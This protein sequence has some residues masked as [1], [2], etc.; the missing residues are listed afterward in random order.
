MKKTCNFSIIFDYILVILLIVLSL[1][2]GGFYKSDILI[3]SIG[4][5]IIA[6]LY[7]LFYLFKLLKEKKYKT[8]IISILLL[9][10]SFCYLLPIMFNNYADLNSSIF[11]AIRY[12]NLYFIYSIVKKTN[13]KKVYIYTI[14]GITLL[15]CI[16]S[17]DG[18]GNRYLENI[19]TNFGSGYLDRDFTRMSGTLQYA[20][21]L[22]I[23]CLISLVFVFEFIQNETKLFNYILLYMTL[24]TITSA[25][26][27]TG[28]RAVFLLWI[29]SIILSF[30]I[31]NKEI[32]KNIFTY[33][34]MLALIGIYT[35]LMYKNMLSY[36]VYFIFLIFISL[37]IGIAFFT[38]KIYYIYLTKYKE[39][40]NIKKTY[41]IILFFILVIIY[42]IIGFSFSEPINIDANDNITSRDVIL[43]NLIKGENTITF[44]VI[45]NEDDTRYKLKLNSVDNKN[46]EKNIKEFN[47]FD[48]T[49]GNF[50]YKFNLDSDIKY[51]KLYVE[52]EKGDMTLSNVYLN[53]FEQKLNYILIPNEI[54]YRFKDLF[55][56]STST[57]DRINYYIDAIKII[58]KSVPN[59]VIGT[60]GEGFN[61]IYEQVKISEYS[62]TEVHSSFLQIFV[63][64]GIIGF[65]VIIIILIYSLIK[66]KN[67][68]IKFAYIL[69][70][71]HSFI[72]LNFSYMLIILVFGILL[73]LLDYN[74]NIEIN[75]KFISYCVI[76]ISLLS[77]L[78]VLII[79]LRSIFAMYISIPK[80]DEE[81]IN[82]SYQIEVVNKNE[83]RVMLDSYEYNY[84]K[85][86]DKEY[87]IYLNLLYEELEHETNIDKINILNN[88]IK[89]VLDNI[90]QNADRIYKNSKYNRT[91]IMY[92]C[93]IYFKNIDNLSKR[94]YSENLDYGY[95]VYMNFINQKLNYLSD[96]Y[97][98]NSNLKEKINIL[99][100]EYNDKIKM[101]LT[102]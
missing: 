79:S 89:N 34:P 61:N 73:S 56:G 65:L 4:I 93:S 33:V 55:T 50:E 66:T 28:S 8:D 97:I 35:N 15:Q 96:L 3:V 48:N 100:K 88:E 23:L 51:L 30:C 84:R 54:V 6:F 91:Q 49:S 62:S 80:Y 58:C 45:S 16:L 92:A 13:N 25:L 43:S 26:I 41:V 22:A 36:K 14:I 37:S 85:E 11:E 99:K 102:Y 94:Y 63:E 70:I 32:Y 83:K 17:I 42:F 98:N 21:V 53:T 75:N 82:L 5:S 29:F 9:I 95:E 71:I 10:L 47:Y 69:L 20:N 87:S 12:F 86:L 19:L 60:G 74:K 18:V 46:C 57:F 31:K 77:T 39:K 52:C 38:Y 44:Q 78:F 68:Y 59:F 72:D 76:I 64:S 81:N 7:T 40:I 24:F 67:S 1:S 101:S 27:L 2:K 90:T